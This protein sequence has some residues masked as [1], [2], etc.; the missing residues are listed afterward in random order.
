MTVEKFIKSF[1][2]YQTGD[3]GFCRLASISAE[4]DDVV[5][6]IGFWFE[7]VKNDGRLMVLTAQLNSNTTGTM[8]PYKNTFFIGGETQLEI[9][10]DHLRLKVQDQ[11]YSFMSCG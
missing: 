5:Y 1:E 4:K 7:I 3:K 2:S 10:L 9:F 11:L 8:K 6:I